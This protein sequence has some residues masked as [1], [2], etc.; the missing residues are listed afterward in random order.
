MFH[1]FRT[2]YCYFFAPTFNQFFVFVLTIQTHYTTETFPSVLATSQKAILV[3]AVPSSASIK[4]VGIVIMSGLWTADQEWVTISKAVSWNIHNTKCLLL[5]NVYSLYAFGRCYSMY[6]PFF[7]RGDEKDPLLCSITGRLIS[8]DIQ[9]SCR[10][11]RNSH[12]AIL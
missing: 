9:G 11:H 8:G 12:H 4:E 6:T 1:L 7:N 5:G 3:L 10:E 2:G